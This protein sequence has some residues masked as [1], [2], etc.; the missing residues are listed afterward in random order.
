LWAWHEFPLPPKRYQFLHNTL[1]PDIFFQLNTL[2]G[3]AKALAVHL[4][5]LNTLRGTKRAFLT[6]KSHDEHPHHFYMGVPP[7]ASVKAI[8]GILHQRYIDLPS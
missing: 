6:A 3:T 2:K 5:R 1:S 8:Q 7:W 4:L